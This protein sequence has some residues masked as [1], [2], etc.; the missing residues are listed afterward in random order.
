MP[1]YLLVQ[2]LSLCQGML[3]DW[4]IGVGGITPQQQHIAQFALVTTP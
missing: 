4:G 2:K 3:G 1:L